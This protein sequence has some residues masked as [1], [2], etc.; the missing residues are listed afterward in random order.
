VL[1]PL[2]VR[3][4]ILLHAEQAPL[5]TVGPVTLVSD[6]DALRRPRRRLPLCPTE[7][8]ASSRLP[9][10]DVPPCWP[11]DIRSKPGWRLQHAVSVHALAQWIGRGLAAHVL[12]CARPR[13]IDRSSHW[14][15]RALSYRRA[16]STVRPDRSSS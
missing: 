8:W 15:A 1:D 5:S 12:V 2:C 13:S 9:P 10:R 14:P 4:S 7:S 11:V 3:A 6:D 16:F